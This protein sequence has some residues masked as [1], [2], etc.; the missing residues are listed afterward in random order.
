M[1]RARLRLLVVRW[2]GAAKSRDRAGAAMTCLLILA[3][4]LVGAVV[5]MFFWRLIL[6]PRQE[7]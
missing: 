5:F 3:G 4:W 2:R 1:A 7:E 6:A